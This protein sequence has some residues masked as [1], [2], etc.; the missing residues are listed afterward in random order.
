MTELLF[1]PALW[2]V[3]AAWAVVF[4]VLAARAPK[5]SRLWALLSGVCMA[6]GLLLGLLQGRTLAEGLPVVLAVTAVALA[7][8]CGREDRK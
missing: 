3:L 8:L 2:Y 1:S 6:A 4:A 7:G 5:L